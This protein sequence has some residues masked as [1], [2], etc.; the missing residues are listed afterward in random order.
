MEKEIKDLDAIIKNNPKAS[1]TIKKQID[2]ILKTEPDKEKRAALKIKLWKDHAPK[3]AKK[4][5]KLLGFNEW[6]S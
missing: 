4:E 2:K 5:E 6:N 3:K 1:S